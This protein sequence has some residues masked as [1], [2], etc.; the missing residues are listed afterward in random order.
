MQ[1]R[2]LKTAAASTAVA[3]FLL[4]GCTTN[5]GPSTTAAG[6]QQ[7]I[8]NGVDTTMATLYSSAPGSRELAAKA[9]GILVFPRVLTAGLVIGGEFGRGALQAGGRTV[10]YYKTTGLSVGL[11]AGAQSK[12]LV[13]MFMTQDALDRFLN[14][15]GWTAG[16]DAS[17]ALFKLGA[18]GTLDSSAAGAAVIAFALT[19]E[20]LM[21]AA[22]VDG[23]KVSKLEF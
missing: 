4:A 1:R 19:N 5:T 2:T 16:A 9:R 18:N 10:G 23:T 13:F 6:Q 7:S 20:G 17:V 15:S 21:A 14:G 3:F 11:Q 22:T 8:D 12:S